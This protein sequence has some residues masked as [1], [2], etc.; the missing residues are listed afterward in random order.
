MKT[1]YTL[2][3]L[4]AVAGLAA[5]QP[6]VD[7]NE[8]A[9]AGAAS[10]QDSA[11]PASSGGETVEARVREGLWQISMGTAGAPI[12]TTRVCMD[13]RMSAIDSAQGSGDAVGEDCQQ[14]TNHTADGF[15][16][17]SRCTL[18]D[19]SVTQTEGTMTGDME[20]SYRMEATVTTSGSSTAAVNGSRSIVTEGAYQG[21]CP[22]GWRPGDMELPGGMGRI[23]VLDA[24]AQITAPS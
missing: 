12:M 5:C 22:D 16:F 2:S 20:T 17:S 18:A 24:Q 19:G 11:T 14:T 6:A 15:D 4:A 21:A 7:A 3:A 10:A 8:S 9:D 13:E 1:L 23:N